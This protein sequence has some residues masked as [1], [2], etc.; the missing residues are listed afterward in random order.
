[1]LGTDV[2]KATITLLSKHDYL[3]RIRL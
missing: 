1:M 2:E 3:D